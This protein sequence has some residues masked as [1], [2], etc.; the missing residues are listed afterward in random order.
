[1]PSSCSVSST[2]G[3]TC[4]GSAKMPAEPTS[5]PVIPL[6]ERYFLKHSCAATLRNTF[7]VQTNNML[8]VAF[9]GRLYVMW[10]GAEA[11]RFELTMPYGIPVF[12]TGALDQLCDASLKRRSATLGRA[13][14]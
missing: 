5:Q 7:P 6:S 10:A 4:S 12:E 9:I 14:L 11:V 2:F 13:K 3:S 1:M 8:F